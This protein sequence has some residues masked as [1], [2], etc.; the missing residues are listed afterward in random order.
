A[1]ILTET[2]PALSLAEFLYFTVSVFA[3]YR[4]AFFIHELTHQERSSLPGFSL[5]WNLLLGIPTLFPSFLYRGVHIDHHRRATYGTDEDGEYLPFG[6]SPLWR[7]FLYL[8]Q[9][10]LLPFVVVFRFGVIAPLSLMHPRLR[11]YV[12]THCSSLNIRLDTERKIP[13]SALE[14]RNWYILESLCAAWALVLALLFFDGVLSLG[15]LRHIYLLMTCL[16]FVNSVRTLVAHRYRNKS[17]KDLTFTDQFLDSVN[18]EG[19][20]LLGGLLAPVGLRFHALHHLFPSLPYHSLAT[21]HQRLK[22][23]LPADSIYHEATEPSFWAAFATHWRNTRQAANE[24]EL[25]HGSYR[26]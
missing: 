24:D 14:L 4:A 10:V 1:F 11:F 25:V 15:T 26:I 2:A 17:G 3:F 16:F 21:A 19:N 8:S 12:M 9:T 6:A 5:A 18:V 13:K 7:S 22:E 23:Q 20:V